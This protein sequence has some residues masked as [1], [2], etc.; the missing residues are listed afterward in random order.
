MDPEDAKAEI[1]AL[2]EPV[3]A[4]VQGDWQDLDKAAEA[5]SLASGGTGARYGM[6]RIGPGVEEGAQKAFLDAVTAQWTKAGF[7]P[8]AS[9]RPPLN[10]VVVTELRFPTTGFGEDGLYLRASVSTNS[11]QVEAQTRCV[12]GDANEINRSN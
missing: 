3:Q 5:C 7:T 12:P 4:L 2:I 8:T 11:A 9:E 1:V 6:L 10:G